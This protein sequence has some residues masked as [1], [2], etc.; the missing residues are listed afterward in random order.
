MRP[1]SL[2]SRILFIC[3]R[4][5]W[6]F[7]AAHGLFLVVMSRSHSS[8]ECL[9]FSLGSTSFRCTLSVVFA[10]RLC[11]STA[12]GV[13]LDQGSNLCPLL[14]Q[15]DSKPLDY[16][17]FFL[18]NS[19]LDVSEPSWRLS[20]WSWNSKWEWDVSCLS[21]IEC[22][23][24]SCIIMLNAQMRIIVGWRWY[25]QDWTWALALLSA[26]FTSSSDLTLSSHL[27]LFFG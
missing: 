5:Y 6:V 3:L 25:S 21:W 2:F 11:C 4:L 24:F 27:P 26:Q 17:S 20:S 1:L 15:S 13:F 7:I 9:G 18:K 14:W 19:S 12:C 16:H 10:H 8:L 22:F 23:W